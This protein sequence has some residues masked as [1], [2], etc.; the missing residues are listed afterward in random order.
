MRILIADDHD[1]LR[2][3]L[4]MFLSSAGDMTVDGANSYAQALDMMEKV[5]PYDLLLLDY[6]MPGMNGLT[7]LKD[8]LEHKRAKHVALMSG[9][10]PRAVIE[11]AL[12]AGAS[13]FVPKTLP[14]KSLRNAVAF[15]LMGET[16]MP[17]GFLQDVEGRA[18]PVLRD[19]SRREAQVL[20][21]LCDGKSN[22]E[23]GQ[24]L[25]ISEATVKLHVKTIYRHLGVANRTQAA[26]IARDLG[27]S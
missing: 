20:R 27:F 26:M 8:A 19:L 5:D 15:M 18:D 13:G 23:I 1:L 7:G 16:Y 24:D 12:N 2:D 25:S 22:K 9:D 17:A 21:G 6:R 4:V 14:A 11:E 10:A 3:T